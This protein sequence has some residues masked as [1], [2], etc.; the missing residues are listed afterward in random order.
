M[1]EQERRALI[2]TVR[3][4]AKDQ[5]L[6]KALE[7]ALRHPDLVRARVTRAGILLEGPGGI[8]GCHWSGVES[9]G[10]RLTARRLAAIGLGV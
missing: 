2:R 1:T 4:R 10:A 3:A 8:T 5:R 6:R 9:A 7:G